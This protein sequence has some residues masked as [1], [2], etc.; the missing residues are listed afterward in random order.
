MARSKEAAVIL[1]LLAALSRC[2][3]ALD[4][5]LDVSQYA[6]T[7]WKISEGVATG[8]TH[9]IVQT[10]E[11]YLWLATESSL[12]RFDGVHSVA[13]QPPAGEHLPS[14][15]IRELFAARD[16]T[17]WLGTAKGLASWKDGKLIHY[18]Q[19]DGY[20]VNT[21]REDHQGTVWAAGVIWE[22]AFYEP[23]RLSAIRAG[24]V[25]CY[26]DGTFGF[27]VTAI[28]ED[29]KRNLWRG[30]ANGLGRWKPGPPR[31]YALPAALFGGPNLVFSRNS[32]IEGDNGALIIAGSRDILQFVN[33]RA[34]PYPFP[35]APPPFRNRTMLRDREGSL[36]ISATDVGIVHVHQGRKDF[37]TDHDG[38]SSNSIEG[39]FEDREGRIW[40]ATNLGIDRFREYPIPTISIDQGLSS[41]VVLCVLAA[42]DGSVRLGTSDGL[43]RWNDGHITIYR[44]ATARTSQN[45]G[46]PG[47]QR[48]REVTPRGLPDNFITSLFQ[49]R[50]GR[51]WVSTAGGLAYFENGEFSHVTGLPFAPQNPLIEDTA[52]DL[53]T[54]QSDRGLVR[55]HEGNLAEQIPWD[56][57]EI[58]GALANP[59]AADPADGGLWVGSWSGGVIH[60]RDGQ[61]RTF[62]GTREELG[63]GRVNSL[64]FDSGGRLWAA[65][66]CGLTRISNGR[67]ITLSSNNG[68]PCDIAQ[69]VLEDDTHA[70]WVHMA[71]GLVRIA[72]GELDAWAA[73]PGRRIQSTVYGASDG[74]ISH[75]GVYNFGPRAAKT[76]DG[77][78]WFSPVEGVLVVDPHHMPSN[79]CPQPVHIEEVK[80]DD[81]TVWQ[82]LTRAE[83]LDLRLPALTR[84]LEIGYTA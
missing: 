17:L 59:L 69:D 41:R 57:L 16:G 26:G 12:R 77:R 7:S 47:G 70:L 58:G 63:G 65:T 37:F 38:L 14:S 9:T 39:M 23:G 53:W 36:W 81:E 13:W 25:Q 84:S 44:K 18:P 73:N 64:Q 30:A 68:L 45:P 8:T 27:G 22:R 6:H 66:D 29:S 74:V 19:F 51:I 56:R 1:T 78:L 20:D 40:V 80:G 62:Y 48:V 54:A 33:G 60:F 75:A 83:A 43:N 11:G 35:S 42:R 50:K 5:S 49:D 10:K 34:K 46:R 2:A 21:I 82:N 61:V 32:L 55:L 71:C 72:K 15:D 79:T 4:P 24:N 28:H 52:G 3:F 76:A 31:H 67:A